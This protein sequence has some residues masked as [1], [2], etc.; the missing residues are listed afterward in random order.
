M[1]NELRERILAYNKKRKEIETE[2]DRLRTQLDGIIS[3][4]DEIKG[5]KLYKLLP[6]WVRELIKKITTEE[7]KDENT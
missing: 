1:T 5:N 7:Q 3:R 4:L 2:R 6:A